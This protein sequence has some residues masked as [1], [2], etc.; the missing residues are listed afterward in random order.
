[1]DYSLE[2]GDNSIE[3]AEDLIM[4]GEK[5][6]IIDDLL[7]TGGTMAAAASLVEKV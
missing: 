1:M 5:V 3:I 4:P 7:A 2:Y 6:A